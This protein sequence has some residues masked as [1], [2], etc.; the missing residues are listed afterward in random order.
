MWGC[1]S[2]ERICASLAK[3]SS[4]CPKRTFKAT[5]APPSSSRARQISPIPPRAARRS[6]MKRPATLCP[7]SILAS[8]SERVG[9]LG[10]LGE[11]RLVWLLQLWVYEGRTRT[12]SAHPHRA[13]GVFQDIRGDPTGPGGV[14]SDTLPSPAW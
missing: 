2:E 8:P 13:A 1:R 6:T 14:F 10:A 3:R 4:P 7:A 5:A 12:T 9:D 11:D